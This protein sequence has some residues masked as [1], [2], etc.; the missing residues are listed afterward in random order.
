MSL[1]KKEF[2]FKTLLEVENYKQ[3]SRNTTF[4]LKDKKLWDHINGSAR[5]PSELRKTLD[6]SKDRKNR[7]Y[8]K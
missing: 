1:N 4:A 7:I 8:Q 6:I 2:A 3:W 5:R